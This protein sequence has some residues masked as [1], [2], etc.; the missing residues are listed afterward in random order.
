M[1]LEQQDTKTQSRDILGCKYVGRFLNVPLIDA[2]RVSLY[3]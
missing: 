1:I 2:C 3:H